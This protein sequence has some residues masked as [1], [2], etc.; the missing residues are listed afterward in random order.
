M[1]E[2]LKRILIVPDTHAPYHDKKAWALVLKVAYALKWDKIICLGDFFDCYAVSS[3]RKNPSREASLQRELNTAMAVMAELSAVPC[4][5]KV[6]FE[7]NHEFRFPRYLS[8]K[9]PELYEMLWEN[10][11]PFG[12]K[13]GGWTVV[14]YM[15]DRRIGQINITHDVGKAGPNALRS[16]MHDYMDNVIIGHTHMM[17]FFIEGNAKGVP[18]VGASF[19]WLGDVNRIDYKHLMKSR[20]DF[21]LGFGYAHLRP[22]NGCVYIHPVPIV[23]YSCIIEGKLFTV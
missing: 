10:G 4:E 7:G 22:S 14:P 16:A 2:T 12:L 5:E 13:A 1:T 23:K 3:Y 8:D 15:K 18:H 19:G 11:D 17:Q 6:F 21:V 9:A 20:K